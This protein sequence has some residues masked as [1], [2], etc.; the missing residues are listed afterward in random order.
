MMHDQT[1][2]KSAISVLSIS[3]ATAVYHPEDGGN[4]CLCSTV[5]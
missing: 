1:Q 3:C 5:F 2:I 4:K